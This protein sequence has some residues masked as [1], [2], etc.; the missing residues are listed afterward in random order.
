MFMHKISCVIHIQSRVRGF[1]G[2]LSFIDDLGGIILSQC[3]VR[4]WIAMRLRSQKRLVV[5]LIEEAQYEQDAENNAASKL[6]S[7]FR[8]VVRPKLHFHAAVKVQSFFRMVRA[9]IER[10]IR[11]EM[12]RRKQAARRRK[13]A[14]IK[15]Q[16]FWRAIM[17]IDERRYRT[18]V[19]IQ[20]QAAIKVQS[21]VRMLHVVRFLDAKRR[22]DA[23]T[24]IQSFFRMVRAMVDRE[25]KEQLKRRKIRKMLKNRTKEI[26]DLMLEEAW[27]CLST[28]NDSNLPS[29]RPPVRNI[30]NYDENVRRDVG[31]DSIKAL[32]LMSLQP[33]TLE[34][35]AS[36]SS[37]ST[38]ERVWK[39]MP[40]ESKA[41]RD[42]WSS[43]SISDESVFEVKRIALNNVSQSR[44]R[45]RSKTSRRNDEQQTPEEDPQILRSSKMTHNNVAKA[46]L[47]VPFKHRIPP[48]YHQ[49]GVCADENPPS[50]V[51]R[52]RKNN[53]DSDTVSEVSALTTASAYRPSQPRSRTNALAAF[54]PLRFQSAMMNEN[55]GD[56]LSK[57]DSY[58]E[59]SVGTARS[60]NSH[61]EKGKRHFR[62]RSRSR[63][64]V[65]RFE[66]I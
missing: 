3:A 56:S 54:Q 12:N 57:I 51:V 46:A 44:I 55:Y 61:A 13:D 37:D 48:S 36:T 20:V 65:N 8:N 47:S 25:I 38:L 40:Q 19:Q 2:R 15:L 43:M 60:K 42:A 9:I 5:M 28:S 45:G 33:R 6:Q 66:D 34:V 49:Q 7:W 27:V 10:E 17:A 23:A 64:P 39:S 31:P 24:T 1:I 50:D 53:D 41:L 58:T 29:V 30:A 14:S 22:L 32:P 4:R 35:K 16:C 26:D 59:A 18:D 11:F 21:Y 52:W 63:E 62:S